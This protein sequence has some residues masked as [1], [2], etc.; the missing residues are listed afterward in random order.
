MKITRIIAILFLSISYALFSQQ[1]PL[2]SIFQKNVVDSA[3]ILQNYRKNKALI[4]LYPVAFIGSSLVLGIEYKLFKYNSFR[5][6]LGY[7]TA[8]RSIFYDVKNLNELYSELQYRIYPNRKSV[9]NLNGLFFGAY[10]LVKGRSYDKDQSNYTNSF[11]KDNIYYSSNTSYTNQK[12]DNQAGGF[13][14]IVG[15]QGVFYHVLTFDFYIGGGLIL[16]VK[17]EEGG[18]QMSIINSYKKE[19]NLHTGLSVGY[20]F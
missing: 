9:N 18:I 2:Q 20:T 14:F 6:V 3:N 13:G 17:S 19:V 15:A 10:G 1:G 8:E 11:Y 16:P 7:S 5:L 12:Y 4:C